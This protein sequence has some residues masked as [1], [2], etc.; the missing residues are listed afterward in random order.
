MVLFSLSLAY[1]EL[2]SLF[3]DNVLLLAWVTIF[4]CVIEKWR[5]IKEGIM[6]LLLSLLAFLFI[7]ATGGVLPIMETPG[8]FLHVLRL[9][10]VEFQN[11]FYEVDD[12]K[13][14]SFLFT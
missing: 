13:L 14:F 10:W 7:C 6:T 1:S 12:Y 5:T 9:H 3:Y 4:S 2:S 8:A 11:K